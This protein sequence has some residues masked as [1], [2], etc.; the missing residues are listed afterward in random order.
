MDA[1]IAEQPGL[2]PQDLAKM[3]PVEQ[4]Y[5]IRWRNQSETSSSL[6]KQTGLPSQMA[7]LRNLLKKCFVHYEEARQKIDST[8][9]YSAD[10]CLRDFA[11]EFSDALVSIIQ[12][13][14]VTVTTTV[15]TSDK[16][17]G[18]LTGAGGTFKQITTDI[19][20]GLIPPGVTPNAG[21]GT[22]TA[23]SQDVN[24]E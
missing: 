12:C 22:G 5:H 4:K 7:K 24:I 20:E 13:Q 23:N 19:P 10:T 2:P 8:D 16:V 1:P 17:D 6:A 3:S 21:V 9:K 18:V 15:T 14:K 11:D